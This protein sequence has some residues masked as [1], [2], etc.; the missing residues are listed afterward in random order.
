MDPK[1]EISTN[2]TPKTRT[3]SM[4]VGDLDLR[5]NWSST[6][7]SRTLTYSEIPMANSSDDFGVKQTNSSDS[8]SSEN[9]FDNFF[10]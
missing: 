4:V 9:F 3:D 1:Y 7:W 8:D 5:R 2:K 6:A 10:Q